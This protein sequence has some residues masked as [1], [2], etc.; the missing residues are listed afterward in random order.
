MR[1]ADVSNFGDEEQT[2]G[3][4]LEKWSQDFLN[5]YKAKLRSE[6]KTGPEYELTGHFSFDFIYEEN[7]RQLYVL[8][9]NVVSL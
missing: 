4:T 6:G 2:M 1:Y 8:E 3:E 9:C 7:E 5:M